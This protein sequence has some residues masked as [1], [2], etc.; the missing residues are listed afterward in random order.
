MLFDDTYREEAE[1]LR[2][3]VVAQ[4]QRSNPTSAV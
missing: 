3:S 4:A 1:A 2:S